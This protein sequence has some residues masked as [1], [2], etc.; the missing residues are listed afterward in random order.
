MKAPCHLS[1]I[2]L[3]PCDPGFRTDRRVFPY[4]YLLYVH[5]GTGIYKIGSHAFSAS[6]G[7]M[8]YCPPGEGNAILAD[9]HDPFVLSGLEFTTEE[10]GL[11]D[12]LPVRCNLL[13]E[14]FLPALV[15]EMVQEYASGR[16]DSGAVCD[17]LLEALLL[18]LGRLAGTVRGRQDTTDA[19]L[20]YIRENLHREVTHSELSH[21]F[22]YHKNSLNRL[23]RRATG[24]SLR[25]YQITLRL[26]RATDL[27]AYSHK[28]VGEIAEL[29]G[30]ADASYF[31][32]QYKQKTGK[33]PLDI[34]RH[35]R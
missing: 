24:Q 10:S 13:Q 19:L 29:C 33:S 32:R 12:N 1:V 22:H 11:C 17:A 28:T 35:P 15:R 21:V 34:R 2:N 23:L 25:D 9:E 5:S 31:S 8:F 3:Y 26:R 16:T 14:P 6:M 18:R 7:D 27:L 30:Y 4:R 20:S